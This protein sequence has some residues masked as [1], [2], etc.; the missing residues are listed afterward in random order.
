MNIYTNT[1]PD[2][3]TKKSQKDHKKYKKN[4]SLNQGISKTLYIVPTVD[5]FFSHNSE[6]HGLIFMIFI[7]FFSH[8]SGIQGPIL[9][10]FGYDSHQYLRHSWTDFHYFWI[11]F[12]AISQ[13]FMDQFSWFLD[14]FFINISGIHGLIFM[15]FIYIFQPYL[16]NSWTNFHDFLDMNF[17]HISGIIRP[18]FIIFGKG[19]HQYLRNSWTNF[20][21]LDTFFIIT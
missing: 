18:I 1:R 9:M 2:R 15:I 13:Q 21:D 16:R 8:I 3:I 20:H 11:C 14:M 19:F 12:S 17:F 5:M 7:M 10:I 6:F 4:H